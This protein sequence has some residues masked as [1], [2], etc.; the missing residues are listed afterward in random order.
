MQIYNFFLVIKYL[1]FLVV[2]V[3]IIFIWLAFNRFMV[4]SCTN[5]K[6]EVFL[7]SFVLNFIKFVEIILLLFKKKIHLQNGFRQ[8]FLFTCQKSK[9]FCFLPIEIS[10]HLLIKLCRK[11]NKLFNYTNLKLLNELFLNLGIKHETNI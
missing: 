7:V 11:G 1:Y 10:C 9:V 5:E 3:V 6:K 2:V 4:F 8:V